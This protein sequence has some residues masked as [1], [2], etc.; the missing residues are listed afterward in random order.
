VTTEESAIH[1]HEDDPL[2]P[3]GQVLDLLEDHDSAMP[4]LV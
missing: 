4:A 3:V 1:F 2:D